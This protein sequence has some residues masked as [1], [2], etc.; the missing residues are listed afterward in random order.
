[1]D[2]E[3]IYPIISILQNNLN[4]E[5]YTLFYLVF[6]GVLLLASLRLFGLSGLYL[7]NAAN[8]LAANIQVLGFTKFSLLPEPIALGIVT[9]TVTFLASD[10]ITEHYG[11]RKA[12]QGVWFSLFLQVL[13]M[14][15][16]LSGMGYNHTNQE[17]EQAIQH[18]FLPNP[19]IILASLCAYLLSQYLDI[20]LFKSLKIGLK[21]RHLWMRT[22]LSISISGLVD[23]FIFSV[24]A[25]M[26]FSPTPI[27]WHTLFTS[28]VLV[29]YFMRLVA[30]G[31]SIPV[32]YLSYFCKPKESHDNL[33]PIDQDLTYVIS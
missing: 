10:V 15:L 3:F 28:Y 17:T 4:A 25:W 16:M 32:I 7:F 6:S 11:A 19:R 13:F 8:L 24:L 23:I 21:S 18:L 22:L 33:D 12:Q 26:V 14:L 20:A 9:F 31:L 29:N 27:T 30:Q 5:I 1:M 2:T